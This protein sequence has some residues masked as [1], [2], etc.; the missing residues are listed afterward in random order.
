LLASWRK[1]SY[2]SYNGACVEV[3]HLRDARIGVRDTKDLGAGPVLT[4]DAGAWDAFLSGVKR[5]EF[6]IAP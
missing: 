4:F 1:S 2:S 5:D 3:A 6:T